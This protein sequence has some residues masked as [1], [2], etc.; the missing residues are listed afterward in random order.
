MI[1]KYRNQKQDNTSDTGN[2]NTEPYY[3]S[4][5]HA[6]T[7]SEVPK[8][9]TPIEKQQ[10]VAAEPAYTTCKPKTQPMST[11]VSSMECHANNPLYDYVANQPNQNS[12]DQYDTE[13]ETMYFNE[14]A[15]V[16][17]QYS[18]ECDL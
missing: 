13:Y 10:K 1:L 15:S 12:T 2:I 16:Q 18:K 5:A 17:N 8:W 7:L 9:K 3:N 11:S 6:V 14:S 4:S